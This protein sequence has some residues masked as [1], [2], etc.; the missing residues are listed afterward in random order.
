MLNKSIT[1]STPNV[2]SL[3]KDFKDVEDN[4]EAPVSANATTVLSLGATLEK[5][6]ANDVS[7]ELET[8]ENLS[9]VDLLEVSWERFSRA[10]RQI[11]VAKIRSEA[12][13]L[14]D[15]LQIDAGGA[16][17]NSLYV[18]Q[19]IKRHLGSFYIYLTIFCLDTRIHC[20]RHQIGN[21]QN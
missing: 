9:S 10:E 13:G 5:E 8:K 17:L 1:L 7:D 11:A 19:C 15:F 4:G 18:F 6:V 16:S 3:G 20:F 14:G 21:S 2:E 12:E